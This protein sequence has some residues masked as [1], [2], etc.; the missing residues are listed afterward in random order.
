MGVSAPGE[1]ERHL[2]RYQRRH[3]PKGSNLFKKK[4]YT[5]VVRVDKDGKAWNIP[6]K[7][8][9]RIDKA[10]HKKMLK[11]LESRGKMQEY[12]RLKRG[13]NVML[14]GFGAADR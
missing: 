5:R 10:A 7:K 6:T 8:G 4:G 1:E 13:E 11:N 3:K 14:S 9:S 12:R 2:T